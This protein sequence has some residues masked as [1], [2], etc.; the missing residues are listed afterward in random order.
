MGHLF[1]SAT[2][3]FAMLI[4]WHGVALAQPAVLA[5]IEAL[6]KLSETNNAQAL[7]QLLD[8]GAALGADTP[9]TIRREYLSTLITVQV[10]AAKLD[11]AQASTANLLQL[12]QANKDNVGVVI[13]T[14][15][16]ASMF[17][18]SGK[19]HAAIARLVA[20]KLRWRAH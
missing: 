9:Y 7:R 11:E 19:A 16:S 2:F 18:I 1:R 14:S 4:G 12:A 5:R 6:Q 13:A 15:S 10:D 8:V 3:V 17:N 20:S